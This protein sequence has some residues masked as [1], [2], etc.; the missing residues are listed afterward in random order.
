[1]EPSC[2]IQEKK[3]VQIDDDMQE[4]PNWVQ[5]GSWSGLGAILGRLWG[6]LAGVWR[7]FGVNLMYWERNL[8]SFVVLFL[9]SFFCVFFC[10][11]LGAKKEAFWRCLRIIVL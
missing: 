10:L 1:M 2:E 4:R 8:V 7:G 11:V 3:P 9:C 5:G 6:G